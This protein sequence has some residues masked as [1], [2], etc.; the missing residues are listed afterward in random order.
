MLLAPGAAGED[1]L[2]QPCD[3]AGLDLSGR[4]VVLSACQSASGAVL[5]GEGV[6]SLARTF[7]A[8]GASTVMGSL[9]RLRDDEAA[10]LFDRF[11]RHLAAGESVAGALAAAQDD[12]IRAGAPAAAWAGLAILGDGGVVPVPGER[13]RLLRGAF[14]LAPAAALLALASALLWRRFAIDPA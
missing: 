9:W 10:A 11:Y 4:V 13:P 8:V 2:L 12:R 1:G 6:L 5:R 3:I 14:A 7:F